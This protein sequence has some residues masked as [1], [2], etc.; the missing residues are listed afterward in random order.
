MKY[1]TFCERINAMVRKSK[2]LT[3]EFE[4]ND[5]EFSARISNGM[6]FFASERSMVVRVEGFRKG[7]DR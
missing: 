2:G 6:R 3:V 4:Q 5:G 1:Q 7:G